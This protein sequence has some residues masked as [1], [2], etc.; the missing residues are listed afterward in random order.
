MFRAGLLADGPDGD[1]KLRN[2]DE[3][4]EEEAEPRAENSGLRSVGEIV[5]GV[6]TLL[7]SLA[8]ADVSQTDGAPSED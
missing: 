1:P 5:E 6:A 4:V 3:T 7:P 2:E 8:E